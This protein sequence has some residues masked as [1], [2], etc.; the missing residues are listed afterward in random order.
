[1]EIRPINDPNLALA[2]TLL[3]K[4]DRLGNYSLQEEESS[5]AA[6]YSPFPQTRQLTTDSG[7]EAAIDANAA[8]K[9]EELTIVMYDLSN[10]NPQSLLKP[11]VHKPIDKQY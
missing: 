6:Q 9:D 7:K 1:M 5:Q 10:W 4:E 3:G 2:G 8:V 11:L